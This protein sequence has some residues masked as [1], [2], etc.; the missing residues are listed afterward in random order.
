MR[1]GVKI[2]FL[3]FCQVYTKIIY[4]AI[5][6]FDDELASK[7][8]FFDGSSLTKTFSTRQRHDYGALGLYHGR[9]TAVG[10]SLF[11]ANRAVETLTGKGWIFLQSHPRCVNKALDTNASLNLQQF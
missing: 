10:G 6:C 3:H 11:S 1:S 9:P 8:E 7:C 4:L 5:I 2:I